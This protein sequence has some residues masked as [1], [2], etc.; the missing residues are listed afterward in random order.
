MSGF[1]SWIWKGYLGYQ[2]QELGMNRSN[3]TQLADG[4]ISSQDGISILEKIH[5]SLFWVE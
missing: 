5:G 2:Y 1:T 3:R 4:Q